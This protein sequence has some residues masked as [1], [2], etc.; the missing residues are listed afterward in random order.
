MLNVGYGQYVKK[1]NILVITKATQKTLQKVEIAHDGGH[2]LID[3]TNGRLP[4]SLIFLKD[5]YIAISA[6]STET[7][8]E[9][10]RGE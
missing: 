3:C 5:G 6:F 4:E 9:R 10:L 8:R 2:K 1:E 7:L